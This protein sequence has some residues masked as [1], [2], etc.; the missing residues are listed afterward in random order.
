[1][2]APN[3]PFLED[4]TLQTIRVYFLMVDF[5]Q[6]YN[7]FMALHGKPWA[8][9]YTTKHIY[10]LMDLGG[11]TNICAVGRK[12]GVSSANNCLNSSY[13]FAGISDLTYPG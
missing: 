11:L 10:F 1:M 2:Y 5:P 6:P 7:I 8:N 13:K 3:N 12:N 9:R 4:N